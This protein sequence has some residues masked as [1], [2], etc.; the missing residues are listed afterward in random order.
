[1]KACV[2]VTNQLVLYSLN[3][4]AISSAPKMHLSAY[5]LKYI[6]FSSQLLLVVFEGSS[7]IH[8]NISS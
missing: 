1:M 2:V 7:A 5:G 8:D 4:F 6:G 3:A